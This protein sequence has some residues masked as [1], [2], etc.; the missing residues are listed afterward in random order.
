MAWL[1]ER[2]L[3]RDLEVMR[4]LWRARVPFT[5]AASAIDPDALVQLYFAH[6]IKWPGA[7]RAF[8]AASPAE[9]G[10]LSGKAIVQGIR[11][12]LR[13][14]DGRPLTRMHLGMSKGLMHAVS[15][16]VVAS[17][18]LGILRKGA[19]DAPGRSLVSLGSKGTRYVLVAEDETKAAEQYGDA[20]LAAARAASSEL[21]ARPSVAELPS[22]GLG[23][24]EVGERSARDPARWSGPG[25]RRGSHPQAEAPRG[26]RPHEL[27][28]HEVPREALRED[29]LDG[30]S[31]GGGLGCQP[32]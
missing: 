6:A 11:A 25:G 8:V 12:A 15:G 24:A 19:A 14:A 17:Q 22:G 20:V 16:L 30:R 10:Q 2:M 32:G 28:P 3:P 7:V 23:L 21:L 4:D 27:R 9:G 13:W 18:Q 31:H 26:K 29:V 1:C 5:R